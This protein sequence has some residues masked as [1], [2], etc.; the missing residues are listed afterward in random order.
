[1]TTKIKLSQISPTPATNNYIE[2][3]VA[4]LVNSAPETLDTLN[5]LAAALGDDPNF[6][7]TI[8]NALGNK[9][10]TGITVTGSGNAVTN[11]SDNNGDITVTKGNTF[12][13][14]SGGTMTGNIVFNS[15]NNYDIRLNANDGILNLFG[16]SSGNSGSGAKLSL[17]GTSE[18]TNP[19]M[20]NL[21]AGNPDGTYKQLKGKADGTLTWGGEDVTTTTTLAN[22]LP[23]AGGTTTG[24]I[25]CVAKNLGSTYVN[26]AKDTGAIV[27]MTNTDSFG[28]WLS[29]YTK[30]YKVALATYPGSTEDVQLY[31]I[32]K[33]NVTAGTNTT[34][35]TLKWNASTGALTSDSF[36]GA[37]TGNVTGNCSGTAANVTGTVA[38][39]HGGTGA[40]TRLNALKALTNED[41]GANATY[42]LT[43]TNSWGKGGYTSVANAK[44]VL[45]LKSA[46]YTESSAYATSGH[47]HSTYAPLASPA[48]TGTPTAPTATAATNTTQIA[49]TAFVTNKLA[50]GDSYV[51]IQ[52]F[53]S[54]NGNKNNYPYHRIA[55]IG[56]ITGGFLTYHLV[57]LITGGWNGSGLGIVKITTR[58]NDVSNSQ[59]GS[60]TAKWAYRTDDI[61]IDVIQIGFRNTSGDTLADVFIKKSAAYNSHNIKVLQNSENTDAS[62]N[63]PYTLM[64]ASEVNDTT[65]SDKKTSTN[66]Y[67]TIAA[68]NS[69]IWTNKPYTSTVTPEDS[70]TVK[71][72]TKVG[73]TTIGGTSQAIYLDSGTPTAITNQTFANALINSLSTGNDTPYDDD[74]VVVQYA[75]GGTT[76]TTFHRKKVSVLHS[77]IKGKALNMTSKNNL[78]WS[79]NSGANETNVVTMN[80][81]A[82]W[83][84]RYN[85]SSSNLEYCIKGAFGDMATKTAANYA[86]LASPAFTGTPTAPTAALGTNTT[87]IATTAFVT[88]NAQRKIAANTTIFVSYDGAGT[89]DGSS[90]ANALSLTNMWKWLAVT[91]MYGTDGSYTLTIKFVPRASQASYGNIT[92]DANKMPGIRSIVIDTSTG[93]NSTT[94]NFT[95][96][97]P[98]FGNIY[99]RGSLAVTLKNIESTGVISA[100]YDAN[101]ALNTY[102][103]AG[104][105]EA[106]Y[107]GYMSF[108]NGT[109]NLRNYNTGS[110]FTASNY[111]YISINTAT[112][113]FNFRELC[114]YTSSIFTLDA[115]GRIYN[116]YSRTKLTGT[117]PVVSL[118]ASGTLS[119]TSDTAAG[120]AAKVVTTTAGNTTLA[121]GT[122]IY[123]KFTNTN[124]AN[125]PTLNVDGTGAKPI[126]FGSTNIPA[127]YI[128]KNIQYK[129][130]YSTSSAAWVCNNSFQRVENIAGN[131]YYTSSGTF[132]TTYN[133][134]SW[135]WTGFSR[136]YGNGTNVNSALYS[137]TAAVATNTT[138]VATTAFVQSRLGNAAQ[139]VYAL[140]NAA[141]ITINPANGT[142]F[143]L[144][145]N[146][147]STITIDVIT[148]GIYSPYGGVITLFIPKT[149]YVISWNAK[150]KW[151][152]GSAPDLSSGYNI[153]TF[154]TPDGGTTY[155]GNA[156]SQSS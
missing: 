133:S 51:K 130:T 42:F 32:T 105:F 55:T 88:E 78:G 19:G 82:Y 47:T 115:F 95:T 58:S 67:A 118:T 44:T 41:V 145:P 15:S 79:S 36:V 3:M 90:A 126:Y 75:N 112:T 62:N 141:T 1:M 61:P 114:Y 26:A 139:K 28:A 98:V 103:G 57:L 29:G 54:G 106:S 128:N 110:L 11:I 35:K 66:V 39:D 131:S 91:Q 22:Y 127:A 43:I 147:N 37:L 24:S 143:T 50:N 49:T 102:V 151:M 150:I 124:T 87:Q 104:R 16:G 12:L 121:N 134:G 107:W 40:T 6:A 108:G 38:I 65:A 10:N 27:S 125:N 74:Y 111:G 33:A 153:L 129:L 45:G 136:N 18:S 156:I 8:S 85:S 77:Y 81:L 137:S 116:N 100:Q 5:E 71:S 2:G 17:Y 53:I 59:V 21:Q 89:G 64:S 60:I 86:L 142:L 135:N 4:N 46:A 94:S 31:S 123:V 14:L 80:T 52:N 34:N 76:T 148:S 144:T 13:P 69:E 154:A 99:I 56:P 155:Y 119:G 83:N 73:T 149:T 117:Q 152:D 30:S 7:T 20:F 138:Q 84:G 23:L 132:S 120:T 48:L 9:L 109:Y 63:R 93:T 101:I 96:N 113:T 146:R 140:T 68:A 70:G 122:V 25:Q 92:F 97:S 72:A